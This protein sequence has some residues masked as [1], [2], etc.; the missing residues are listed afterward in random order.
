MN[1]LSHLGCDIKIKSYTF[2]IILKKSA[3]SP[4]EAFTKKL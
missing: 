2:L 4:M 1:V 3:I